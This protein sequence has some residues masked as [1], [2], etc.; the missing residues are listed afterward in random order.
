PGDIG[1][2]AAALGGYAAT[3]QPYGFWPAVGGALVATIGIALPSFLWTEFYHRFY[4]RFKQSGMAEGVLTLMRPLVP[5]LMAAAVLLLCT[6]GTFGTPKET[7]WQF[8]I[9]L[10]L[11]FA[12]LIGSALFRIN[13]LVM[14]ALCGIAGWLLL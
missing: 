1:Q 2:N 9:T 6:S 14:I 5:G 10:F 4:V 11:F 7:P 13:S 8:G 12:T 3:V